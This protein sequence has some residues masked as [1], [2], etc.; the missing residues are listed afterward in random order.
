[1]K[2]EFFSQAGMEA[3]CVKFVAQMNNDQDERGHGL[4]GHMKPCFESCCFE[5]KRL[6]LSYFVEP[7][8]RNPGG[9]MHGGAMAAAL[10]ITMGSLSY[11]WTGE[12]LTPT[13]NMNVSYERP[14]MVGKR[15]FVSAE[16]LS[17]G[18]SMVYTVAKAWMEGQEDKIVGS[19]AGTYHIPNRP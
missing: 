13:I 2:P 18:K 3:S 15:L 8:M 6:V 12:C 5:D 1:M 19:A 10:D 7:Y 16:I 14:A 9:V 4:N 17:S 11:Y